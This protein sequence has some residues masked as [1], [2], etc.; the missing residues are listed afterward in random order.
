MRNTLLVLASAIGAAL[1][2]PAAQAL[3]LKVLSAG[4]FQ[5]TVAALG[6]EYEKAS[7]NK[8]I[9][10]ADTVGAL[11]KRV[12]AGEAFDAIVMTPEVIDALAAKGKIAPFSRT[13]LAR[14]GV[15]VMVREGAPKPDI[16]T[17]DAFKK[18]VLDAK[19]VSYID[20][21]SGGS[22][23]IYVAKLLQRLG[24]ADQVKPKEKL[25]Q[26]GYVAD[27]ISSGESELGIHQISEIVPAKGVTLV[28]PLPANIQNYTVYAAG[29]G[30]G[31]KYPDEAKKL[32]A[33]LS[34]PSAQALF[35]SKG[36]EPAGP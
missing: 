30:P 17:V 12:E 18:A 19:S 2:S 27:L 15:G 35:K 26:G 14:V 11:V 31:T 20:P 16:A 9:I 32:I 3:E 28:G 1:S 22:S 6:P 25:K 36:M 10:T 24:I 7:G 23:G 8:L 4:A 34:G 33:V 13:N 29:V 21:A 5:S